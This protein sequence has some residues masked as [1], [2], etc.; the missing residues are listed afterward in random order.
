MQQSNEQKLIDMMFEIAI[1]LKPLGMSKESV[2][3]WVSDQLRQNGFDTTPR[4]LS[5]GVLNH[6]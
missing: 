2:A 5:W 6:G 3:E 1:R 4:G